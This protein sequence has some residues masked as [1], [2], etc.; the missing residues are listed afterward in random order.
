MNQSTPILSVEGLCVSYGSATV[1]N[2]LSFTLAKGQTLGIV[3]TSGSG[4]ST[5]A[6][7]IPGLLPDR[8]ITTGLLRWSDS[9]PQQLSDT[10]TQRTVRAQTGVIFQDALSSL[11]PLHSCGQQL[12]EAIR[13]KQ[14]LGA[15]AAKSL[16]LEW[17]EKV[18]LQDPKRIYQSYPFQLSGGQLQRVLIAIAL[19]N[20][21]SL[22][23]AD[24]PTTALDAEVQKNLLLLLKKIQSDL[25]LSMLFISHDLQVVQF[26][27]DEIAVMENGMIVEQGPA[28]Q[29][30]AYPQSKAAQQLKEAQLK[31][32][33]IEKTTGRAVLY[34]LPPITVEYT[35][36]NRFWLPAHSFKAVDSIPVQ[37]IEGEC[38]GIVGS[39]GSGKSSLAKAIFSQV[40][41]ASTKTSYVSQHPKSS[42]TPHQTIGEAL[43]EVLTTHRIAQTEEDAFNQA[44]QLLEL[45][46]LDSRYMHRYPHQLS[47]GE[48]QR[49]VIARSLALQPRLL[50]CDEVTTALDSVNQLS[51]LDL[52]KELNQTKGLSILLIAHDLSVVR[53]LC[54]RIM[55]LEKGKRVE[56]GE[57]QTILSQP[58]HPATQH[59]IE[60]SLLT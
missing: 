50:I 22:L 17:F 60:S 37:L 57:M 6:L 55:V 10:A 51:I 53:Y 25:D 32:H 28:V 11:N 30:S 56:E 20:Q 2:D 19:C 13:L 44:L 4:K 1:V 16:A 41:G 58:K 33:Q 36:A 3:G 26:M 52:L 35:H 31:T 29:L 39:S 48:V 34:K 14:H 12:V 46:A 7:A 54:H 38:L 49:A 59:L 43:Q 45:V 9:S 15:A 40:G 23:I 42:L 18:E 21:P 8:S 27:A 5:V 24:E 47:G